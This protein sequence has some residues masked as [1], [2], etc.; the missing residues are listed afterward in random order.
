MHACHFFLFMF[1]GEPVV[2]FFVNFSSV[3][4][5]R[6]Q[7]AAKPIPGGNPPGDWQTVVGWGDEGFEPGTVGQQSGTLPLSH[8]ASIHTICYVCIV[9]QEKIIGGY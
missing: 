4:P 3:A 8:H 6:G 7:P 1:Y 2:H 9:G 5:H